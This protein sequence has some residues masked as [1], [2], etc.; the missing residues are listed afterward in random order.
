MY[1]PQQ[2]YTYDTWVK[3]LFR[4]LSRTPDWDKHVQFTPFLGQEQYK[5]V[6]LNSWRTEPSYK[7][8]TNYT[9]KL[10][11]K[12]CNGISESTSTVK[13]YRGGGV[14]WWF[15]CTNIL[16][17]PHT[18]TAMHELYITEVYS[19]FFLLSDVLAFSVG[20]RKRTAATAF[21]TCVKGSLVLLKNMT[22]WRTEPTQAIRR[23]TSGV[24]KS[25][26]PLRTIMTR[27]LPN[28][29]NLVTLKYK[30]HS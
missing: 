24:E 18:P 13:I 19:F 30:A 17:H 23:R 8:Q 4:F 1:N 3:I 29:A 14:A 28:M 5:W 12:T 2:I 9:I 15:W 6:P 21:S 26:M 16:W 11:F 20:S 27:M 25:N 7:I 22:T 10:H